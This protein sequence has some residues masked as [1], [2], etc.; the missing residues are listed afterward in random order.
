MEMRKLEENQRSL[1]NGLLQIFR[2]E[3]VPINYTSINMAD[4]QYLPNVD[5]KTCQISLSVKD[6]SEIAVLMELCTTPRLDG[7][8]RVMRLYIADDTVVE[9]MLETI[10]K[11]NIISPIMLE[12]HK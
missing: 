1:M 12:S 9:Q 10:K 5:N 3:N 2:D 11:V 6:E 7:K 8:Q 4:I